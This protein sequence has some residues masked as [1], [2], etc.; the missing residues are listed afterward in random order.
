MVPAIM[1]RSGN[2]AFGK[3]RIVCSA[4]LLLPDKT[5]IEPAFRN[6]R[7]PHALVSLEGWYGEEA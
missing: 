1:S 4:I 6:R 3:R 5:W 2:P 7:L